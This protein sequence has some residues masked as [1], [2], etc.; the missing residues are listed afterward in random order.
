MKYLAISRTPYYVAYAHF[1]GEHLD[2]YGKVSIRSLDDMK[3]VLEIERILA[4]L[5]QQFRPN[6]VLT[7]LLDRER[8]MKKDIEKIVE[9]RTI[10][11]LVC[12]KMNVVYS[13]FQTSGWELKIT[14][15]KPTAYQKLKLLNE[16][17]KLEGNE[18]VEDIE[19]ANAI[20]L[21]EGVAYQRL[22]KGR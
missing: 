7:H 2:N 8:V 18:T 15:S 10:L 14:N 3:R 20:I 9:I 12:E 1:V 21:A 4:D 17:Y 11:K 16:G 13:E 19:V 22:Q 5:I 6:F